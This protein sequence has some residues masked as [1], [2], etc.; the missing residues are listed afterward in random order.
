MT[1]SMADVTRLH[2]TAL[3]SGAL[4]PVYFRASSSA[5]P[6]KWV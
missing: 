1:A 6:R 4:A 5:R 3:K 2:M